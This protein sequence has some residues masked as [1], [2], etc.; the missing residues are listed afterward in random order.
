MW[1]KFEQLTIK[2]F[3]LPEREREMGLELNQKLTL[4]KIKVEN[5]TNLMKT[6]LT[7]VTCFS[8]KQNEHQIE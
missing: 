2:G 6:K 4:G 1:D 3:R 7:N 8:T 5:S